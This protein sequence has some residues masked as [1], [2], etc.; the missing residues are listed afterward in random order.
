MINYSFGDWFWIGIIAFP[1]LILALIVVMI[2][3]ILLLY[4][5][6]KLMITWIKY[7]STKLTKEFSR[8]LKKEKPKSF[9][10]PFKKSE[11]EEGGWN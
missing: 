8:E 11:E 5:V 2:T 4:F 10:G 3:K 1:A 9:Y 6:G 7:K